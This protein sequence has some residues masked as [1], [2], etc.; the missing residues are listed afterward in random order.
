MNGS[1]RLAKYQLYFKNL[2]ILK[3]LLGWNYG[4]AKDGAG[5]QQHPAMVES[6][7]EIFIKWC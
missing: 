3:S 5:D 7:S 2:N 6:V 4:V 1:S